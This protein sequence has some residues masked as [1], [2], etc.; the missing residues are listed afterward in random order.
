MFALLSY[1]FLGLIIKQKG[2][3]DGGSGSV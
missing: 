3:W 1:F 2:G